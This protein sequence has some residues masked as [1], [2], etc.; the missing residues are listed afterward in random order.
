MPRLLIFSSFLQP[1]QR[2]DAGTG[3]AGGFQVI[4]M[5][6]PGDLLERAL[7]DPADVEMIDRPPGF[8][9][10]EIA[11]NF[12]TVLYSVNSDDGLRM[13]NPIKD[14]PIADAKF[15]QTGKIV[16][17]A[18]EPTMHNDGGVGREP[19]DFSLD[20]GTDYGVEPGHLRVGLG[21]YFDTV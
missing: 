2:R 6:H 14:A 17:H 16:W 9:G 10:S 20:T 15:A 7:G 8:R 21:T 18:H 13:V 19:E 1:L 12:G 3:D 11:I 5:L 4:Q